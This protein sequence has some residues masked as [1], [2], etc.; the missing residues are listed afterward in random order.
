MAINHYSFVQNLWILKINFSFFRVLGCFGVFLT[1]IYTIFSI[2][3]MRFGC[4]A[5]LEA[6]GEGSQVFLPV[7]CWRWAALWF[8]PSHSFPQ[9]FMQETTSLQLGAERFGEK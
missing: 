7:L 2:L 1:P 9:P 5:E 3:V 4:T 8:H 6:G